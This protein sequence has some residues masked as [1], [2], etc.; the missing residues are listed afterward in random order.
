VKDQSIYMQTAARY[1]Y[2]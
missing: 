1:C 2:K